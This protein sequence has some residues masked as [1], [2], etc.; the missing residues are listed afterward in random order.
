LV[1]AEIEKLPMDQQRERLLAV[2]RDTAAS[3]LDIESGSAINTDRG[4][5]AMGFDSL[6]AVEFTNQVNHL[7]DTT[8]AA[9]LI[10]DR[11]NLR[12][13]RDFLLEDCFGWASE[14]TSAPGSRDD[15]LGALL[16]LVESMDDDEA[17]RLLAFEQTR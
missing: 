17:R 5:F 2:L 11:P 12:Q 6:T 10:F 1:R 15:D 7:F 9:T 16:A 8:Y 3:V 13:L 4:L 14:P